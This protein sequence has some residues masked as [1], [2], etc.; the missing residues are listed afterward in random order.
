LQLLAEMLR[1]MRGV[2]LILPA[3][4]AETPAAAPNSEAEPWPRKHYYGWQRTSFTALSRDTDNHTAID[5]ADYI[6]ERT[7]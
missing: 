5:L 6:A 4:V 3:A 2:R 7:I 1:Q